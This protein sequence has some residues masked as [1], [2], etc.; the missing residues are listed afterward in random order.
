MLVNS[1]KYVISLEEEL[2]F[3]DSYIFLIKNRFGDG[4]HFEINVDPAKYSYQLPPLTL[5]LLVEN[6]LKHNQ[7]NKKRP[8][9]IKVYTNSQN[10]LVV[11]N[12]LLP[13][14]QVSE[15]SGLGISN[16]IKR[17]DLLSH[18]QPQILN[19]G[20]TFKVNLPLIEQAS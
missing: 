6:A 19:T 14:E 7:T 2:N 16:I 4:V 15:S 11:E 13:I 9:R 20:R 5:Q 18:L 3:L 1:K 17:Y 12:T 10:Q 8:L